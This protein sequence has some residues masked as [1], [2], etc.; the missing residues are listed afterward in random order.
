MQLI[1]LSDCEICRSK[2]FEKIYA[3]YIRDGVFGNFVEGNIFRCVGCGVVK[4]GENTRLLPDH[5]ES[6]IYRKHVGQNH[7]TEDHFKTHDHLVKYTLEVLWPHSLRNKSICDVGCGAGALLDHISGLTNCDI[8]AVEPAV[9]WSQSLIDRGYKWFS[10]CNEAQSHYGSGL[11]YIFS[12]QV[13]EHVEN[14]RLFL[15]EIKSLL[16]P[17]G[18]IVLSTPNRND[19]LMK[20]LPEEFPKFFYRTQHNWYF[21]VE[22]LT[23]CADL[24]GLSVEKVQFKQ[25]YPI[26]NFINWLNTKTPKGNTQMSIFDEQLD[27][28][29]RTW[30]EQNELADNLYLTLKHKKDSY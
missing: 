5:Y 2:K 11:D 19:I 16:A 8:V 25:R 12:I 23:R 3:G 7:S 13:I 27:S 30:L 18:R 28:S 29:W 6:E 9:S 26:S 22:S 15:Q 10:S 1:E 21:D 14:P 4:I 20:L 24:A 17:D